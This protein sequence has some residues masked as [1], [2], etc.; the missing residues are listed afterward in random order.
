M[1][2]SVAIFRLILTNRLMK[3]VAHDTASRSCVLNCGAIVRGSKLSSLKI[4]YRKLATVPVNVLFDLDQ[5]HFR[6]AQSHIET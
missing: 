5:K 6:A 1:S 4:D 2:L 3:L